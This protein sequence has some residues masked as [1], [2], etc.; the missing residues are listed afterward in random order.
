[1][2]GGICLL[3][4]LGTWQLDRLAWKEALIV[5]RQAMLAAP[6]LT[7]NGVAEGTDVAPYRRV[8]VTGSFLHDKERVVGPRTRRGAVG[9]HMVTPLKLD[10]GGMVLVN[11][12]WVPHNRKDPA[13][14]G[15]R[16]GTG[17]VT[18]EGVV[19]KPSKRGYF[20]PDNE[21]ANNQWFHIDPT[22]LAQALGLSNVA[23][24]WVIAGPAPNPGGYPK[25]GHGVTM[26]PNNHLQYA[27]TWFGLALV[28]AVCL[29]VYW[30]RK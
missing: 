20:A 29:V 1:M 16:Q 26:P 17:P 22:A 12:G 15:E 18:V 30:R 5:K 27:G 9:W 21:P 3:A 19:R 6:P 4:G 25:G 14:R 11:R 13:R 28:F 7:L 2:L 24:Y 10:D 23:P 8:R